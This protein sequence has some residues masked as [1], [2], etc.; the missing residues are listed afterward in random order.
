MRDLLGR[1]NMNQMIKSFQDLHLRVDRRLQGLVVRCVILDLE[2]ILQICQ[3]MNHDLC[4]P[5]E[6]KEY[7]QTKKCPQGP[8]PTKASHD[9][10][11]LYVQVLERGQLEI[12]IKLL[13]RELMNLQY[14]TSQLQQITNSV[15]WLGAKAEDFLGLDQVPTNPKQIFILSMLMLKLSQ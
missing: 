10:H 2:L 4:I 15:Q 12:L 7:L 6:T 11:Q 8:A 5:L 9:R 13:V 1:V 3:T 14:M